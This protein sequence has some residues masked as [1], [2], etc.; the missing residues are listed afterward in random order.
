MTIAVRSGSD[1]RPVTI[2]EV[3]LK[4]IWDVVSRIKIG[5][6][7]KASV[8]DRNGF[9][10]ADPDIGLVLR[11]TNLSELPH[12]KAAG[13]AQ[14]FGDSAML[15]HDFAGTA[16]L[17]SVAPIEALDW[18]AFVEQPVSEVYAKLDA[19]ILRTGLL[20][21]VGLVISALGA[22]ALAR[23][24]VRPIRTLSGGAQ[25][26]GEGDLVPKIDVRTADELESLAERFN[27]MSGQL[28]ESY[29]GL[30]RKVEEHTHELTNSLEQRT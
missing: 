16:V 18:Y 13:S 4:F 14:G 5:D 12:V 15:S 25:R 7:G 2:A 22:L 27:R 1:S 29:P 20:L 8:V 21:L 26:I 28:K 17:V 10:V 23:G 30:E 24:M 6:K 11:K 19:S 9:L 3:N